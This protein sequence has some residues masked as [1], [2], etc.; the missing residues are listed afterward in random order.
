M[1]Q[2][3]NNIMYL[4]S[5]ALENCGMVRQE[6][7]EIE[8]REILDMVLPNSYCKKLFGI[9]Q[10]NYEQKFLK[11]VDILQLF[12]PKIKAQAAKAKSNKELAD[13][14]YGNKGT[15]Y[16]DNGTSKVTDAKKTTYKT[17][18]K[19]Q[20]GEYWKITGGNTGCSNRNGNKTFDKK[21]LNFIKAMIK[22]S[23]SS[24]KKD[25]EFQI[26]IQIRRLNREMEEGRKPSPTDVYCSIIQSRQR[27]G[28][29]RGN[30]LN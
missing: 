28:L 16:N 25:S 17:C 11:T 4:P 10:N 5:E 30:Q 2:L 21:Q 6:F 3:N 22:S 12:E 20:K 8:M 7:T 19:Q 24:K 14:V 9:R 26:R 15:K 23:V 18:G 27:N 29:G 1:T 13:R